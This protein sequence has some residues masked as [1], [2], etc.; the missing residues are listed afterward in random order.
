MICNFC[1]AE[2]PDNATFCKKCGRR[3]DGMALCGACGKTTPADGEFCIHCGSNRNA[4]VYAMPVRFPAEREGN[5][6]QRKYEKAA[7]FNGEKKLRVQE[8]SDKVRQREDNEQEIGAERTKARTIFGILALAFGAAAALI[9][10]IFVFLIGGQPSVSTSGVS[11]SG[12]PVQSIFYYFGDAYQG[13][14]AAD[15]SVSFSKVLSAVLGT[16]CCTV[17]I[18]AVAA[19]FILTVL[20]LIKILQKKT[21]KSIFVPA[22]ATYIAYLCGVGLFFLCAASRIDIANVTTSISASGATIAGI[23]L[24]G[25]FLVASVVF[26]VVSRGIRISVGNFIFQTASKTLYAVFSF[27][28][29]GLIGGGALSYAVKLAATT[30]TSG[31]SGWF[32]Q[33]S[34]LSSTVQNDSERADKFNGVYNSSLALGV[35]L[36]IFAIVFCIFFVFAFIRIF[37]SVGKNTDKRSRWSMLL[38]GASAVVI[39]IVRIIASAIY[40]N[41]MGD[42]SGY[43]VHATGSVFL[44]VFGVLMIAV[45]IVSAVLTKKFKMQREEE[46]Q[47]TETESS[48][49]DAN[50]ESL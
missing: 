7:V 22:A 39:G 35:L 41:W 6:G 50:A 33:L 26:G 46:L 37:E 45:A 42:E 23:V 4:P 36:G 12:G 14:E 18:V 15:G 17:A 27:V 48:F 3:L 43:S 28:A 32:Q 21:E 24:G 5:G 1:E 29:L 9:G 10:I 19:G 49:G 40:V 34:V 25:I 31:I 30:T 13:V 2:N 16:L 38:S 8:L 11:A 20:R 44:M 47:D